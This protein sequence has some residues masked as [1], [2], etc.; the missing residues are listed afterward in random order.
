[1]TEWPEVRTRPQLRCFERTG[2]VGFEICGAPAARQRVTSAGLV[3]GYFCRQ[4]MREGDEPIGRAPVFQEIELT[5]AVTIA[6][7]SA[8]DAHARAEAVGRLESALASL[9]GSVTI[10]KVRSRTVR[11]SPPAPS[12]GQ[13]AFEGV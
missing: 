3:V 4:H 5:L 10:G 12:G 1:M 7:A 11:Y 6:G 2:N 8:S 13:K 9:T